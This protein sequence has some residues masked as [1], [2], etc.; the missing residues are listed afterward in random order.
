M[1]G[2]GKKE[3]FPW[4]VCGLT[5]GLLEIPLQKGDSRVKQHSEILGSHP[6]LSTPNKVCKDK[7][8]VAE[9]RL[10]SQTENLQ[11][12]KSATHPEVGCTGSAQGRE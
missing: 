5:G 10:S 7:L 8:T 4:Q 1:G 2:S 9:S 6:Y 11:T 3:S 12:S